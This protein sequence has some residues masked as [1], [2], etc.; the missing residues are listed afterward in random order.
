MATLLFY[1]NSH[2]YTVDGEEVPSVSEITRFI[3]RE[4]YSEAPQFAL[5]TASERGHKIHKAT[6]ILDKYGTVEADDET[7]PYIRAYVKFL[8]DY[9]PEWSKI[10]WAVHKGTEYAG[11]LDRYG[12]LEGKK[13]IVDVKSTSI[14]SKQHK[15][16]YTAG[17]NLYRKAIEDEFPVEAIKIL[18]LKKDETYKLFDIEIEDTLADSCLHLHN[19]LKKT[20][21]RKEIA[22]D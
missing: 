16:L 14:I 10:E 6:E 9:A 4:V 3:N 7:T 11:T 17:Q 8:K 5:D 15:A 2:T 13:T 19:A 12:V 22:N 20:R 18:Q 1:D 21:R